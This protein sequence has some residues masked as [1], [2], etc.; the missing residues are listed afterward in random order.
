VTIG[1]VAV[2]VFYSGLAPGL[3]GLWQINA[4]LPASLPTN[5]A[6]TLRVDLKGRQSFQTSL[7]VANQ[8]EF[9]SVTGLV[10]SA[11]TGSPL[12][13]ASLA[14]QGGGPPRNVMTDSAGRYSFYIVTPGGYTLSAAASGF[15]TATQGA[16][17]AGGQ[18]ITAAPIALTA[19]L[20]S[21]SQYRVVVAWQT[22]ID[23]DGHLTGP[24][25]SGRFHVWW[26]EETNLVNPVTAQLDRDDL[27][28]AGPET[29]TFTAGNGDYNFS[30]HNY[31][32]RDASGS[33]NL[34]QSGV[35]VRVYQGNQQVAFINAPSGGGTLWKVFR[36]TNGVLSMVNQLT[37][38]L[39]PSLIKAS[40]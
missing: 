3:V 1:G 6:T 20:A 40:F 14:L 28:G 34:A 30:V 27:T 31:M 12:G 29:V 23:L 8:N 33:V 24:A 32:G 9:G 2:Q 7:A 18:N 35:T 4:L 5:M 21:S 19:P 13:G 37:D 36:I 39:D 38:E 10:V 16:T 26:N 15:I 17:I 25:A 22:G 11:L